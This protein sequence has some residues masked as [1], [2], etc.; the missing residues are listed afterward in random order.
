MVRPAE[1]FAVNVAHEQPALALA[2]R[3]LRPSLP[4][5]V[6][7]AA[8]LGTGIGGLLP[9][10]LATTQGSR[11]AATGPT[12]AET[13]L[14]AIEPAAG[15]ATA[16]LLPRAPDDG[17]YAPVQFD[18]VAVTMRLEPTAPTTI[19]SPSDAQR[20]SVAGTVAPIVN[21]REVRL[22]VAKAGPVALAVASPDLPS[23][24]LG[25]DLLDRLAV[26]R[27]KATACDWPHAEACLLRPRE[28]IIS[29]AGVSGKP[30]SARAGRVEG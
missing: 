17:F 16:M 27:S 4:I 25:A 3:S 20:L 24:I 28:R 15:P 11:L 12:A 22:G 10:D 7:V 5:V 23:S 14:A 9:A 26:C 8:V 13:D 18:R 29:I 30:S 6:V 1:R 21:V 19:L 2:P